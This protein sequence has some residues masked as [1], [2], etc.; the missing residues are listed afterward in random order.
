MD[1]R[2]T[3]DFYEVLGL[4]AG[5]SEGEIRNA[6]RKLAKKYHPDANAG[7]KKA[8]E[9]F[10]EI[11]EAY[12]VLGDPEKR[13]RYDAVRAGGHPSSPNGP[14][15]GDFRG[16][17]FE[18]AEFGG[19]LGGLFADLFGRAGNAGQAPRRGEDLEYEASIEFEEAI[20]GTKLT[21]P[22]ARNVTCPVCRG[23][24]RAPG[25]SGRDRGAACRRCGGSGLVRSSETIH[26]GIP[27]G[28]DDGSRV[29]VAGSGE[30]GRRG[31]PAG[32]LYIVLRVKP[33]RYFR[34]EGT[35]I[36]FD[37]PLSFSEAALGAK[38]EVPTLDGRASL[39]IPAGTRSGQRFRLRG[40]GAPA[41]DAH[42]RGDLIAVAAIVPPKSD[43]RAKRLLQ[44]LAEL[45]VEDPRGDLDW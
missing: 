17:D 35:D 3:R 11:S 28:A 44:E 32:D 19:D 23:T 37:L 4:K 22:L 33:H 36:L 38:V 10:K 14:M 12:Q 29:R 45:G 7:S 8:E 39:T 26:V 6:Y 5:A 25:A 15:H 31:G 9:T 1:R 40:K 18:G 30:G 43:A 2:M 24:G 20:R 27:A 41:R 21:V 13:E 42:P 34:R 16:F